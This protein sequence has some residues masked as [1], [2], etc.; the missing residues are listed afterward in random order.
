MGVMGELCCCTAMNNTRRELMR[1][2][3][4]RFSLWRICCCTGVTVETS[5]DASGTGFISVPEGASFTV[6]MDDPAS[7]AGDEVGDEMKSRLP[8]G[9]YDMEFHLIPP[10]EDTQLR[11]IV[12]HSGREDGSKP[13]IVMCGGETLEPYSEKE[14][15]LLIAAG[16]THSQPNPMPHSPL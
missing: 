6:S 7:A 8:T 16:K 2:S 4:S 13:D 5:Q 1:L 11:V 14:F 9:S 3:L 12:A 10:L 15:I